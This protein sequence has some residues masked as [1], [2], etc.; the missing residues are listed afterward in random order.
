MIPK[1]WVHDD[2]LQ[3]LRRTLEFRW[4][5]I[6]VACV[7]TIGSAY[8][9]TIQLRVGQPGNALF[10]LI[11]TALMLLF[12]AKVMHKTLV[13]KHAMDQIIESQ[14][15][16]IRNETTWLFAQIEVELGGEDKNGY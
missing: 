9:S 2:Y 1:V 14:E 5:V 10:L 11:V 4:G 16:V 12:I 8:G 3:G 7:M 15:T 13:F 6:F